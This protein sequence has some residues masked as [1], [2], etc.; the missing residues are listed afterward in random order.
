[1]TNN[2]V[3]KLIKN[4]DLCLLDFVFQKTYIYG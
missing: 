1:M 4:S 3:A 2:R